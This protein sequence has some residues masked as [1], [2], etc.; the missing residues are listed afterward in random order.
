MRVARLWLLCGRRQRVPTVPRLRSGAGPV[1]EHVPDG[2]V[3]L[4]VRQPDHVQ[5]GGATVRA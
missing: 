4:R 5:P 2:P 1:R 3:L